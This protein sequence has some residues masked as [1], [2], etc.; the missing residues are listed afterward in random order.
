[1][2]V[3]ARITTNSQNIQKVTVILI[4]TELRPENTKNT[5]PKIYIELNVK[6]NISLFF[7]KPGSRNMRRI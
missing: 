6:Q 3:P 7:T 4:Y 5:T 1:M 2:T